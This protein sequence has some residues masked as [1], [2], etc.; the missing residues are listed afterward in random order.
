V[1]PPLLYNN[2]AYHYVNVTRILLS[3]HTALVTDDA[4]NRIENESVSKI[5]LNDAIIFLLNCN[6]HFVNFRP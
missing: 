4:R 1:A 2:A 6:Q 5:T 3:L